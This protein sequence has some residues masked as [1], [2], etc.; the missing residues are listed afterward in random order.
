M[1][2]VNHYGHGVMSFDGLISVPRE[3]ISELVSAINTNVV[4]EGFHRDE[5]GRTLNNGG[6]A[7]DSKEK[8]EVAPLRFTNCVYEGIS[9]KNIETIRSIENAIYQAV[10]NYCRYFPSAIP[11]IRWKTRGYLIEYGVGQ[12]MGPHSDSASPYLADRHTPINQQPLCNTLTCTVVLNDDFTGG[13]TGF[14]P[15][16]LVVPSK[17]C[18]ILVFPANFTGCHEVLPVLSGKRYAYL[19]WYCHGDMNNSSP[20][21]NNSVNFNERIIEDSCYVDIE[22]FENANSMYMQEFVPVGELSK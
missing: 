6:Y 8:M 11:S 14:R 22:Q 19:S 5:N 4:P 10:V 13:E 17:F 18:R 1:L 12:Y 3:D 21:F 9:A 16:G 20:K 15:W 7:H 2:A